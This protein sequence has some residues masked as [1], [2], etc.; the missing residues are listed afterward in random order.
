MTFPRE[1]DDSVDVAAWQNTSIRPQ[2]PKKGK[3][4]SGII[5]KPTDTVMFPQNWP[6]IALTSDKVGGAY[7]F[8]DLDIRLF[9]TGELTLLSSHRISPD[10]HEGRIRLL[11]QLISLSRVYEWAV[12]MKLYTEVVSQIENGLIIW[13]S[14]FES[15][16]QWAL[17]NHNSTLPAAKSPVNKTQYAKKSSGKT[18]P[19]YCKEYQTNACTSPEDKH[20]G[21]VN[22][23]RRMVEHICAACLMRKKEVVH[24][25]EMST[26]CP[27]KG[28][29]SRISRQ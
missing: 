12:I 20:W 1:S 3:V 27:S 19:T 13:G 14:S 10:E 16:I 26:E 7:T 28:N 5:A 21:M 24:H 23:E 4:Q 22:G 17:A 6:H 15:T 11:R 25:S 29:T 2:T 9:V 8:Q 18:R